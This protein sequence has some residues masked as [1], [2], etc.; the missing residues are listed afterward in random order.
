MLTHALAHVSV[1]GGGGGGG[2]GEKEGGGKK[3]GNH[4]PAIAN[5]IM[6]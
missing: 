6:Y 5:F 1:C 4:D 3:G 2:G